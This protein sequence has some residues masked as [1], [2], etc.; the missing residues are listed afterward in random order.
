M[1]LDPARLLNLR[2]ASRHVDYSDR[3][4]LLYALS[5]GAGLA[6]SLGAGLAE[7]LGLVHE[8]GQRVVPSFGQNLAF[9]DS[10]MEAAGVDLAKVVHGGLDLRFEAPF[11]P[12]GAAEVIG[13]IVG[14]TDK[15]EG[16]AGIIAQEITVQQH[17][18]PVF[19]SLSSLF[20]R[21]GGGFGGSVGQQPATNLVPEGPADSTQLVPTRPDQALLFRLLGDRNPLHAVPEVARAAG[22]ERPILH[23]ACTFG[24]AC[25]TVLQRFCA[26]EPA[27][28]KR[29]AAR[30]SGPL[31]PGETLAFSFWKTAAGV[32]FTA[33]AHERGQPVLDG[34]LAEITN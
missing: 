10:W 14:L 1:A 17:G 24:I 11:A 22:F 20:V 23:G 34:G 7:D 29:F 15:G 33:R 21:G 27:R 4:T 5:L 31:Y 16:K 3:D 12:A 26:G 2:I 8:D 18:R 6:L 9:D 13:S 19:T 28:M 32:A 25:L 30:F